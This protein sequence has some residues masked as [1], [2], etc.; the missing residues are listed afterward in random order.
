MIPAADVY[1][2]EDSA[3]VQT[4]SFAGKFGPY[5]GDG[6]VE[7][8]KAWQEAL[9]EVGKAV[10]RALGRSR[11]GVEIPEDF[12]DLTRAFVT[13]SGARNWADFNRKAVNVGITTSDAS[14]LEARLWH[15]PDSRGGRT[16]RGDVPPVRFSRDD[17]PK[18]IGALLVELAM[19]SGKLKLP[20]PKAA[21]VARR[22]PK[23]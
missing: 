12:N 17:D 23:R 7:I 13:A 5:L 15:Q 9:D 8:V 19:H 4:S 1:F 20:K 3:Y 16:P 18:R 14:D 6:Q 11:V 21:K 10:L 2:F 22:K